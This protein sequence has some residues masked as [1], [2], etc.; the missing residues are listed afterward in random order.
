LKAAD[1]AN[2]VGPCRFMIGRCRLVT[3]QPNIAG[4]L[5]R[6][7]VERWGGQES[8]SPGARASWAIGVGS[9]FRPR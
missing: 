7:E 8:L 1:H 6:G 9:G 3:I 2:G 4:Y 5:R